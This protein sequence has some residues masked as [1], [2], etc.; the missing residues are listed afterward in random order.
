MALLL[1]IG[2]GNAKTSNFANSPHEN[3]DF[4]GSGGLPGFIFGAKNR[5]RKD[6]EAKTAQ[7]ASWK[8]LELDFGS[9][10]AAILALKTSW[11]AIKKA[12]KN[13]ANLGAIL[14]K[15]SLRQGIGRAS[16]GGVCAARKSLSWRI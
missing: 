2:V 9:I 5:Y 4:Q 11:K 13:R 1:A 10:L 6:M 14:A 7:R 3:V 12:L 15:K 16:V 8:A